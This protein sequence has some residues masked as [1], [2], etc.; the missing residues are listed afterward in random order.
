VRERERERETERER[1]RIMFESLSRI[2]LSNEKR[3]EKRNEKLDE[4]DE[5][6]EKHQ[7]AEIID[8]ERLKASTLVEGVT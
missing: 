7:A 5:K 2:W 6:H 4:I 8:A 1:E 3:E